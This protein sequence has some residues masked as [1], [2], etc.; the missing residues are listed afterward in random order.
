MNYRGDL[1]EPKFAT[2]VFVSNFVDAKH[3]GRHGFQF[4]KGFP[5]WKREDMP[6]P[7]PSRYVPCSVGNDFLIQDP[8]QN[9]PDL[10]VEHFFL[11][12]TIVQCILQGCGLEI[13]QTQNGLEGVFVKSQARTPVAHFG[14]IKFQSHTLIANLEYKI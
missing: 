14:S 4:C 3:H 7:I 5:I 11:R 1:I 2:G 6:S 10:V 12:K 13:L 8:P 9:H